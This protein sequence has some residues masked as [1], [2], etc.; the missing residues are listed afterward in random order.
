MNPFRTKIKPNFEI[1]WG[2]AEKGGKATYPQRS[3]EE[4]HLFD[5]KGYVNKKKE[6]KMS[7]LVNQVMP[8]LGNKMS[9]RP[10]SPADLI[11]NIDA[12]IAELEKEE[13]ERKAGIKEKPIA[14]IDPVKMPAAPRKDPK[15][16]I[17]SIDA[18]IA[19]LEKEEKLKDQEKPKDKESVLS[20]ISSEDFAAKI[21][22]NVNKTVQNSDSKKETRKSDSKIVI[23]DDKNDTKTTIVDAK[24]DKNAKNDK[25]NKSEVN[26]YNDD[27][28]T[29]DEFFDDFFA[30]DDM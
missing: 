14:K 15:D 5:L 8:G 4:V 7:A 19:E 13:K 28:I 16:L 9:G 10:T 23:V 30:D 18:K 17:K 22:K 24:K 11:K 20:N 1:D 27:Y 12:K 26:N 29:D 21:T 25:I 6:E 2:P 3:K